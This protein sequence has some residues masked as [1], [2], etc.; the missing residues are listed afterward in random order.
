MAGPV[1][2]AVLGAGSWGT[3]LA[4]VAERAGSPVTLWARDAGLAEEVARTRRNPRRLPDLELPDGVAVDSRLDVALAG[5]DVVVFAV[6]ASA[7]RGTADAASGLIGRAIP[8]SVAKGLEPRTLLRMTEVLRESLPAGNGGRACAISG[9][10]LA[11]E[12][13]AGLP[14]ATV[15]ASSDPAA[16]GLVAR[17]VGS[18]TFR[19][20]TNDDVVGVEL[21][22]ALKNVVAVAAGI[23]DGLG[24]GDNAKAAIVTRGL[25]EMTRLAVALGA[26]P[27][28]LSGLAGMG[29]LFAT[30][31][32]PL[33]RNLR[34]G[35]MLAEGMSADAIRSSLGE[36]AEG[37]AT[38]GTATEL[39]RRAGVEMPIAEQVRAIVAGERAPREALALLLAREAR[40]ELSG[41]ALDSLDG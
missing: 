23:S 15:I 28:T 16:A 17:A 30:C 33:S 32:S 4:A 25:A 37:L 41:L 39:A 2:V 38:A 20:Y 6:P 22:G 18:P 31:A 24:S 40:H 8:V 29:D 5:A 34:A 19:P 10:N 1:R 11:R 9:P 26:N 21:G 35:G 36:V 12:I 7:M 13:A 14:A 27:L 3:V